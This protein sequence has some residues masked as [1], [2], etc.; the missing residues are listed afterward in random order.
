MER[1]RR[2]QEKTRRERKQRLVEIR[3]GKCIVCGYN[4]CTGA[5]EFHHRDP[6]Q[7]K[8]QLSKENLLKPWPIV[9]KEAEKC[10]LHC[11]NCHRELE[12]ILRGLLIPDDG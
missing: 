2:W 8:F 4:R 6:A 5:M 7:K 11:A 1:Y 12:E 3:G 9:L 10:D